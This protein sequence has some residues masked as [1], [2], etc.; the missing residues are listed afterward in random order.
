MGGTRPK[1]K[2]R[3]FHL[4]VPGALLRIEYWA[5]VIKNEKPLTIRG[6][7]SSFNLSISSFNL[8]IS[9]L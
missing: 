1:I 3:G 4:V 5:D 2:F 8:S 7:N 6:F 9:S